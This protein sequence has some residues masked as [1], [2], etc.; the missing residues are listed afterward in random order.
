M[1]EQHDAHV[2]AARKVFRDCG[3]ELSAM[4]YKRTPEALAGLRRFNRVPDG[5]K[6]PFAWGYHPNAWMRDNWQRY[7]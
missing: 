6:H 7:Y 4:Q 1:D 2:T 3:F 5:W